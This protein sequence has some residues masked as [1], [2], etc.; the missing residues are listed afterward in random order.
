V[1]PVSLPD[2]G[3]GIGIGIG[4]FIHPPHT[5]VNGG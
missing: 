2:I 1:G 5:I 4:Y 3:I